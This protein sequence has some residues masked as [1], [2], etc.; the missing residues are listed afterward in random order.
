LL[1]DSKKLETAHVLAL[2]K[3]KKKQRKYDN[4]LIVHDAINSLLVI[5]EKSRLFAATKV[6]ELVGFMQDYLKVCK[7]NACSPEIQ[8]V[9][10][11]SEMYIK[12]GAEAV[13][14]CISRLD[15][16]LKTTTVKSLEGAESQNMGIRVKGDMD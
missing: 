14:T 2:Y 16:E 10:K 13:R 15:E 12:H 7:S 4:N 9:E 11:I 6:I 1:K 3:S 5:N 8:S